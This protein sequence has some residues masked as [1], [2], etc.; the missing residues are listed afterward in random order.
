MPAAVFVRDRARQLT[1]GLGPPYVE[2]GYVSPKADI[3]E[4]SE[5]SL[6]LSSKFLSHSYGRLYKHLAE[7]YY[8]DGAA[9]PKSFK[10]ARNLLGPQT[11][12][13]NFDH[14]NNPVE[15]KPKVLFKGVTVIRP[16]TPP[17]PPPP[18]PPTE[19]EWSEA[20]AKGPGRRRRLSTLSTTAD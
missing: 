8:A 20:Q 9:S 10:R 7:S 16:P 4:V 3:R 15:K 13:R 1:M 2:H 14:L 19:E 18:P 11:N 17:P 6:S 12:I 5:G